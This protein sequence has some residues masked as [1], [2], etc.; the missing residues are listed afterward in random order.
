MKDWKITIMKTK[1]TN[2]NSSAAINKQGIIKL[3]VT[4]DSAISLDNVIFDG[5]KINGNTN[6]AFS[7]SGQ[8]QLLTI[9]NSEFK[10]IR[11]GNTGGA[12]YLSVTSFDPNYEGETIIGNSVCIFFFQLRNEIKLT[13]LF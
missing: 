5:I 6:G 13:S 9:K 8:V 1:F 11:P 7:L 10:N 12:L 2:L 3:T 4:G